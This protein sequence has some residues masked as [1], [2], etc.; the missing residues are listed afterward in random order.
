MSGLRSPRRLAAAALLACAALA[1][2]AGA[3]PRTYALPEDPELSWPDDPAAELV[4]VH[5]A[6]CHSLDY[7]VRQPTGMPAS[8]WEASVSKMVRAYGADISP[9]EQRAIAAYLARIRADEAAPTAAGA[10]GRQPGGR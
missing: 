5:C 4:Q 9:G 7:I 10:A 8:F 6:A 2:L 1:G 3:A